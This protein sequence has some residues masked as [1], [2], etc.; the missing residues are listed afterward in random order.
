MIVTVER[1]GAL[2]FADGDT[3]FEPGDRVSALARPDEVEA[4]RYRIDGDHPT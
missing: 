1:H 4:L 3:T 2:I